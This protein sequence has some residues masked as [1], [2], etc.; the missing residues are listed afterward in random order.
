MC[1]WCRFPVKEPTT[2]NGQKVCSHKTPDFPT[3][4]EAYQKHLREMTPKVLKQI[5]KD[6]DR[7]K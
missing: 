3:C 1:Y 2:V 6:L 5:K 7:G 4:A